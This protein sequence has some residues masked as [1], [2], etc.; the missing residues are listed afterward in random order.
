MFVL[1]G[2]S[3]RFQSRPF[4]ST[5]PRLRRARQGLRRCLSSEGKDVDLSALGLHDLQSRLQEAVASEDYSTAAQLRDVIADRELDVKIA[6]EF[7]NRRFYEAFQNGDLEAMKSIWKP[8][9]Y[10]QCIHPSQ[11]C[12][13]TYE[14]VLESWKHILST[15][16]KGEFRIALEDLRIHA[17]DEMAVVTCTEAVTSGRDTGHLFATNVFELYQNEWRMI[18]HH[19]SAVR[20]F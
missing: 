18:L 5:C 9:E 8:V 10:V 3:L 20:E 12:I 19:G 7:A 16:T 1:K 4:S 13:A 15:V 11:G 6:V 2:H 14:L 17:T